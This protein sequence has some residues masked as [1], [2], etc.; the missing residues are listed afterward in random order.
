MI[1][2]KSGYEPVDKQS[3]AASRKNRVVVMVL[4]VLCV[5]VM[6]LGVHLRS[7]HTKALDL[8]DRFSALLIDDQA[9]YFPSLAGAQTAGRR[10]LEQAKPN[11]DGS[12]TSSGIMWTYDWTDDI[13]AS[14]AVGEYYLAKGMALEEYYNAPVA[15]DIWTYDWQADQKH[16]MALGDLYKSIG[17]AINLH[18]RQLYDP[19]HR[20]DAKGQI[21]YNWKTDYDHGAAVGKCYEDL[22]LKIKKHYSKTFKAPTAEMAQLWEDYKNKGEAIAKYYHKKGKAIKHFYKGKLADMWIEVPNAA[23][24]DPYTLRQEMKDKGLAINEFYRARYDPTYQ[25]D[26]SPI[27]ASESLNATRGEFPPWGQDPA[28]DK[29]HGKAIGAYYKEHGVATGQYYKQR[30]KELGKYYEN[31]YRTMFDPTYSAPADLNW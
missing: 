26:V 1:P 13:D 28:A 14:A 17:E 15:P 4:I 19:N 22:A 24:T 16:G 2:N 7:Q 29:A 21:S 5:F 3:A 27:D 31:Y 10:D 25:P 23:Q 8:D 11:D 30:G 6:I 20:K 18:Y 9:F 12:D